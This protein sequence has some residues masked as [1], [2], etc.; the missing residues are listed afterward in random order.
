MTRRHAKSPD[1][2]AHNMSRNGVIHVSLGL[3]IGGMEKLLVEFARHADRRR[4]DL[5][6]VSLTAKGDVAEQI[7]RLGWPVI[8]LGQRPGVEPATSV[9]LAQLFR[10][11]KPRIVHTHNTK[12]LLYAVP[13]AHLT[14]VQ[15]IIH[16]RHGQR[17]GAT[18]RQNFLFNLAARWVDRVVSVSSD[19]AQIALQQGLP[20]EKL[21]TIHNG[22]D[23][24]LFPPAGPLPSGPVVFVGRLSPEKDLPTL[25]RAA[26]IAASEEPSFRLH[27]AGA[28]PSLS[29]LQ[30]LAAQLG[31]GHRV[32]FLGHNTDISAILA[33]ASLFVLSS[34]TEGVSLALLEAMAC[35]LPVVAT[36]VGGNVEVVI[37]GET[38]LLVPP[39]S[40]AALAGAMLKLYRQPELARRMGVAG[41][42]RVEARFDSRR[43][44][45]E[46]ESL[47]L[48]GQ[49][50]LAAA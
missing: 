22:I 7:E 5:Q 38:G 50:S 21:V 16:T 31:V 12:P 48:P 11:S 10:R 44:V 40:P 29:E 37:D 19:S 41:R 24:P 45:A 32:G 8:A 30:R 2:R 26:A 39:R 17:H 15:T 28:G 35:R 14:G 47:Y 23:L 3:H 34:V 49:S 43:M 18:R 4:F 46:Y 42:K 20:S 1:P 36:A 25:L 13:A 33:Q 27:L 6:F 9:R